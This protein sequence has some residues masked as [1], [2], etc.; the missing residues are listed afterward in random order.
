MGSLVGD[1]SAS[2]AGAY[3][4]YLHDRHMHHAG[5]SGRRHI[6][7]VNVWVSAC[8]ALPAGLGLGT[9]HAGCRDAGTPGQEVQGAV[10]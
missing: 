8:S 5:P 2:C 9:R 4:R 1:P 6:M 7:G 10:A 3:E